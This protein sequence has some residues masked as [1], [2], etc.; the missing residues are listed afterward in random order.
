METDEEEGLKEGLTFHNKDA[1]KPIDQKEQLSYLWKSS[2]RTWRWQRLDDVG[3]PIA[4]QH[5]LWLRKGG[6]GVERRREKRRKN[7]SSQNLKATKRKTKKM[8]LGSCAPRHKQPLTR[9]KA[10]AYGRFRKLG[11]RGLR[12]E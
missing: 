2:T 11:E 6:H 8:S 4:Q 1:G 3:S 9:N 10:G 7:N 12:D 5:T